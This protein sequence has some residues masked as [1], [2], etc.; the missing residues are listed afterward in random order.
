MEEILS[1]F[2]FNT[3]GISILSVLLI[4]LLIQVFFYINYYKKPVSH[5]KDLSYEAGET[6]DKPSVS[7]IIIAKNES[8]NLAK[9]LPSILAQDYP[10]FEVIV[11]N[12]GSTD[13]SE[14][15]LKKLKEEYSNLYSTFSPEPPYEHDARKQKL[16]SMTIGIKAATKDVLLFTEA[17]TVTFS[18]NWI[19]SMISRMTSAK[20]IVIGYCKYE[21][22]KGIRGKIAAF[23]HLLFTLQYMSMAIKG[24][25]YIGLYRNIAYRKK[26]FFDNKGFSS[27]LKYE[28]A[29]DIFLNTIMNE[30]NTAV[31]LSESGFTAS[32][33]SN[34]RMWRFLKTSYM[35]A[36]NN[37][38]NFKPTIFHTETF[39]R[40]I[41]YITSFASIVYSCLFSLWI[42]LAV[43]VILFFCRYF[44]QISVLNKASQHFHTEKYSLSLPLLDIIQPYCN[45]SFWKKSKK[46][47]RK[48]GL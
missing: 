7:V 39:S 32:E 5:F 19:N 29:E 20:D 22:F 38:G 27:S 21:T 14:D 10:N 36:K 28:N 42:Y 26:L 1:Y 47:N 41:F 17:D 4:A 37:F 24:K 40:Y 18:L 46:R 35:R 3:I 11:V 6:T 2:I 25:P 12:D 30:S 34:F 9:N 23:D 33:L 44:V 43:S 8:E 45:F 13:Q 48:N 16:L 31:A 15:L